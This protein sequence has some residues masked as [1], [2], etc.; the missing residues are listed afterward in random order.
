M[1]IE[2]L[3]RHPACPSEKPGSSSGVG[4][5]CSQKWLMSQRKTKPNNKKIPKETNKLFCQ[6]DPR[7]NF[8]SDCRTGDLANPGHIRKMHQA[9][10]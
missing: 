10:T 5:D 6:A 8:L 9:D 1:A 2:L 7:E 4:T 3:D